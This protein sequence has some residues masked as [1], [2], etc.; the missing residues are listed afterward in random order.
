MC[1][2][3]GIALPDGSS[4]RLDAALIERMRDVLAH[5]GPD[6]CGLFVD[7]GI[8]LGHRRLSIVDVAGGLQP[9]ASADGHLNEPASRP[10]V[11]QWAR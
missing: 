2:I 1:G 7:Q 3:C 6:G 5:R 8:G 10:G 11:P 9:M 4:R